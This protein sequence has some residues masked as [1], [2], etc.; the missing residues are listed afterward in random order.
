MASVD[1]KGLPATPSS[2]SLA[3]LELITEFSEALSRDI[4]QKVFVKVL[5]Y[6]SCKEAP[7]EPRDSY[8]F[9]RSLKQR[10]LSEGL[11]LSSAGVEEKGRWELEPRGSLTSPQR[12]HAARLRTHLHLGGGKTQHPD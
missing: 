6:S 5:E 9:L 4:V 8:S 12:E 11:S 2:S 10:T 1:T 3:K 7:S